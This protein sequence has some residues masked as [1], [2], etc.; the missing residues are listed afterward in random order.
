M[1][2]S[3][4]PCARFAVSSSLADHSTCWTSSTRDRTATIHSRA[5][6]M[7][8]SACRTTTVSGFSSG[9]AKR[10]LWSRGYWIP[11][12]RSSGKSST[13]LHGL[14]GPTRRVEPSRDA[15]HSPSD[16]GPHQLLVIAAGCFDLAAV[17]FTLIVEAA[18]SVV[19][20]V[21]V[22]VAGDQAWC[23]RPF[24]HLRYARGQKNYGIPP[25]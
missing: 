18:A 20:R 4:G 10:V 15:R 12:S 22:W 3:L 25:G 9:C 19:L 23:R 5:G 7:R 8:A 11:S 16:A 14:R 6:F 1:T 2:R 21:S 13:S 24:K 17:L